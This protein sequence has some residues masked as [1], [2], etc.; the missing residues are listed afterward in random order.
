[1]IFAREFT[2]LSEHPSDIKSVSL[3]CR[4][5]SLDPFKCNN[6]LHEKFNIS[7]DQLIT[8]SSNSL[9]PGM[10]LEHGLPPTEDEKPKSKSCYRNNASVICNYC[11]HTP[12]LPTGISRDYNFHTLQ[13]CKRFPPIITV[14]F[15]ISPFSHIKIHSCYLGQITSPT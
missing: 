5:S 11:S 12:T 13:P 14:P 10:G 4:I 6:N 2:H 1:M 3:N 15:F 9:L 8:S 7:E